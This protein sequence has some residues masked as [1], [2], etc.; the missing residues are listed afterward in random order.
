MWQELNLNLNLSVSECV[1]KKKKKRKKRRVV[2]GKSE[3][4]G[5]AYNYWQ[6]GSSRSKT[7]AERDA[8]GW[9]SA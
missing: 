2:E 7:E 8:F 3:V 6:S 5:G 4:G 9:H 1:K